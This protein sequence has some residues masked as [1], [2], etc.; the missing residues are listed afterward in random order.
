[1]RVPPAASAFAPFW[2]KKTSGSSASRLPSGQV[3]EAPTENPVSKL[4]GVL[5]P[6]I[7]EWNVDRFT[8]PLTPSS[9]PCALAVD[10][11]AAIGADRR[12]YPHARDLAV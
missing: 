10:A 6:A 5:S 12:R 8:P 9:S 1:M 11:P 4:Y 7:S 3:M 2:L